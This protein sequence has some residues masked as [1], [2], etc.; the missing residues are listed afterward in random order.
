LFIREGYVPGNPSTMPKV[1]AHV[2]V[3]EGSDDASVLQR[4]VTA[5][6]TLGDGLKVYKDSFNAY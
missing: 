4:A 1:V 3:N 5:D 2:M 6:G